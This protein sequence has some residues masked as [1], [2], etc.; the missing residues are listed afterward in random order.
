MSQKKYLSE[1][2]AAKRYSLSTHWFQRK[3]WAGNGPPYIKVNGNG[4]ILYPIAETDEWFKSFE[5]QT[6]TTAD[7]QRG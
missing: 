3:R 1:K 7:V 6:I 5:L 2:K 4:K